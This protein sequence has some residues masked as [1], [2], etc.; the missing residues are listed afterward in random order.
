M[1]KALNINEL[2]RLAMMPELHKHIPGGAI[3]SPKKSCCGSSAPI[4]EL[5]EALERLLEEGCYVEVDSAMGPLLEKS[6][7]YL[8]AER[9]IRKAKEG[10]K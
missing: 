3:E 5:L 4:K 6:E 7:A 1:S 10:S 2:T 9:I 8:H